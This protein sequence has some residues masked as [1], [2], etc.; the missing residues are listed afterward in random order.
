MTHQAQAAVKLSSDGTRGR[1]EWIWDHDV[2]GTCEQG[3]WEGYGCEIVCLDGLDDG[4]VRVGSVVEVD[5]SGF[6]TDVIR[7]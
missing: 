4:S 1:I 7:Y 3:E 6:C 5:D 2:D